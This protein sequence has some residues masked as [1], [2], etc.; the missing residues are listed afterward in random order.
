MEYWDG[1]SYEE[2]TSATK[3]FDDAALWEPGYT[4]IAYLKVSNAGKVFMTNKG[5]AEIV[6]NGGTYN[7]TVSLSL[8]GMAFHSLAQNN[9]KVVVNGGVFT[10]NVDK[11]AIFMATSNARIE[12]NGGFFENTADKTPDLLEIGTNKNNTNRIVI[13]G[14]TLLTITPWMTGCAI[15]VLGRLPEKRR[16]AV[17]GS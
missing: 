5:G 6:V 14:G 15:P 3:L 7:T 1:D 2:V 12:I 17:L 16:S 9:S 11:A 4:Q 10:S 13:T 8:N